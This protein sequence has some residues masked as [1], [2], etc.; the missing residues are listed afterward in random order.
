MV[1]YLEDSNGE[2]KATWPTTT[3]SL[4]QLK[5]AF[6]GATGALFLKSNNLAIIRDASDN[7]HLQDVETYVVKVPAKGTFISAS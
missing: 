1:V 3:I 2:Q 4:A 5:E 7:Y 6:E